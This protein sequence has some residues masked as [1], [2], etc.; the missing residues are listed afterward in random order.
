MWLD[1]FHICRILT[2][3]CIRGHGLDDN[4]VESTI[5]KPSGEGIADIYAA[6]VSIRIYSHIQLPIIILLIPSLFASLI[7]KENE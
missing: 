2:Q 6:L 3:V 4:D 7:Y 1:H 5:S